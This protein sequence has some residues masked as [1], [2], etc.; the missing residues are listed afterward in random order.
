MNFD[1]LVFILL[2][3]SRISMVLLTRVVSPKFIFVL[4]PFLSVVL[5]QTP[6]AGHLCETDRTVLSPRVIPVDHIVDHFLRVVVLQQV[7]SVGRVHVTLPLSCI[8][9]RNGDVVLKLDVLYSFGFGNTYFGIV[10]GH[11]LSVVLN[12]C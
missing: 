5:R 4:N 6:I 10:L 3:S 11:L 12:H 2:L 9:N 7:G 8:R 1:L